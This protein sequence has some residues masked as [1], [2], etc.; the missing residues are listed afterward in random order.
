MKHHI[1]VPSLQ[2]WD[3][4]PATHIGAQ[5]TTCHSPQLCCDVPPHHHG[6][7][8]LLNS[9]SLPPLNSLLASTSGSPTHWYLRCHFW[10]QSI[11]SSI[12][13]RSTAS[14]TTTTKR[15]ASSFIAS[16]S[17]FL[18]MSHFVLHHRLHS[19]GVVVTLPKFAIAPVFNYDAFEEPHTS[20]PSSTRTRYPPHHQVLST[21]PPPSDEKIG[22]FESPPC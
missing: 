2:S 17:M 13:N 18:V 8:Y 22:F 10:Q 3:G 4:S 20:L 5:Q 9:P 16:L 1:V 21:H 7:F 14:W 19:Y 12:L 15:G 6:S 11:F